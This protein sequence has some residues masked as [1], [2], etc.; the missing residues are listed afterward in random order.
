MFVRHAYIA[1]MNARYESLHY[2][3]DS[4]RANGRSR[5]AVASEAIISPPFGSAQHDVISTP[6]GEAD[7]I[8]DDRERLL[9]LDWVE[10]APRTAR[11]LHLQHRINRQMIK[12]RPAPTQLR[13]AIERYFAG[14][15]L[16][17]S[18]LPLQLGG[19]P[20]QRQVWSAL[21][22]IPAGATESYS[23]L[24]RRIRKPNAS[25]AVGR[26]NGANLIGIVVPCHRV[27]GADRSLTGYGGGL[28]RK[29]WLLEHERLHSDQKR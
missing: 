15:L 1:A 8:F 12:S 17:V 11:L 20:F 7:L 22:M 18:S 29:C 21:Q 25:R 5:S 27:I 19:T 6:L 26:A 23:E 14:D 4:S 9:G 16:A 2:D 10:F 24:S 28:D 13:S 3:Q